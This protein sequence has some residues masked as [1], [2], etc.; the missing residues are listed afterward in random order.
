MSACL[1][2]ATSACYAAA[3]GERAARRGRGAK[4]MWLAAVKWGRGD[5]FCRQREEGR[6]WRSFSFC[7]RR[8][9]RCHCHC[10]RAV[11]A[12]SIIHFNLPALSVRACVCTRECISVCVNLLAV[13]VCVLL[14]LLLFVSL[15][16]YACHRLSYSY[17]K[18]F[19]ARAAC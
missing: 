11:T 17:S 3:R 18:C 15:F 13:C 6:C 8:R 7:L 14:M 10:W 4:R 5:R 16:A 19:V 2:I 12:A 1:K 9:C